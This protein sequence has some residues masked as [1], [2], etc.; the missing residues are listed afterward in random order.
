M[1]VA[2]FTLNCLFALSGVALV[3]AFLGWLPYTAMELLL[4]LLILLFSAKVANALFA[5]FTKATPISESP[6]ITAL[7]LFFVLTPVQSARDALLFMIVATLAM[8]SKYVISYK[9]VHILNPALVGILCAGLATTA[10]VSWWVTAPAMLIAVAVLGYLVVRKAGSDRVF[11][12]FIGTSILFFVGTSVIFTHTSLLEISGLVIRLIVTSPVLFFA[13]FILTD[14]QS[15]PRI[16]KHQNIYAGLVGFVYQLLYVHLFAVGGIA[17]NSVTSGLLG[18]T[19]A[20]I[21]ERRKRHSVIFRHAR[22]LTRDI[23]EYSFKPVQKITYQ[24]GQYF[25]FSIPHKSTDVRGNRRAFYISSSPTDPLLRICTLVPNECSTFKDA[26][27]SLKKAEV[28]S[29]TGPYG[30]PFLP[31]DPLVK[32]CVVAE[33]MGIVPVISICRYLS[34]RHERRDIVLIYS[35]RTP[36]DLVY[37]DEIDRIKDSIGVRVMY[38]PLD[39]TELT[40]WNEVSGVVTSEFIKKHVP[41]IARRES[42]TVLS[43]GTVIHN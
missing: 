3:E 21:F 2:R 12:V 34:D 14:P 27:V 16:R 39:F 43:S 4:S 17:I 19:Y 30:D 26:L 33:G 6:Y 18:N 8:L 35:A 36:L 23:F 25:E 40:N 20:F 41:D 42:F 11:W 31:K 13:A 38:V 37:M 9:K 32:L 10:L 1:T 15:S 29:I 24:P 5:L 22:K 28:L 7:I